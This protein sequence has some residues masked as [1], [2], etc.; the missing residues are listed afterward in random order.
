MKGL[1]TSITLNTI[2][3]LNKIIK[4]YKSLFIFSYFLEVKFAHF[5][6]GGYRAIFFFFLSLFAMI[7]GNSEGIADPIQLYIFVLF[8]FVVATA[9]TNFMF[10]KIRFTRNLI[11]LHLGPTFVYDHGVITVMNNALKGVACLVGALLFKHG[12]LHLT[13]RA[14]IKFLHEHADALTLVGKT[15]SKAEAVEILKRISTLQKLVNQ[16]LDL[17]KQVFNTW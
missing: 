17:L 1:L 8:I 5:F 15:I 10:A 12:H 2:I 7:P 4:F 9:I 6:L 3:L 11:D 13:S 14:N 16:G